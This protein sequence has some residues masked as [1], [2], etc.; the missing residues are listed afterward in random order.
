MCH[1][2]I[3]QTFASLLVGF[4]PC[5]TDLNLAYAQ[6]HLCEPFQQS[7]SFQGNVTMNYLI[8]GE[9]HSSTLYYQM[10]SVGKP[11]SVGLK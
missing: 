8:G 10:P 2:G 1:L 3:N 5:E 11:L 7:L 6:L 4:Q 9:R